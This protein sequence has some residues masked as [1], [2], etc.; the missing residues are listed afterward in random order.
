MSQLIRDF[1]VGDFGDGK[2]GDL[3]VSSNSNVPTVPNVG[4]PTTSS[5]NTV[6][7][8]NF[9]SFSIGDLVFIWQY[10]GP[11]NIVDQWE[12]N[13]IVA[14]NGTTNMTLLKG[15]SN[16]YTNSGNSRAIV[17]RIKRFNNLTVN[18]GVTWTSNNYLYMI[19]VYGTCTIT[20]TISTYQQ[21][22]SIKS[23]NGHWS[24]STGPQG[25]GESGVA[26][27][28]STTQNGTGG[29]GGGGG[30]GNNAAGGGGGG[31]RVV[32][33]NGQNSPQ[34]TGGTGGDNS[35]SSVDLSKINA[36]GSGG[37][38]GSGNDNATNDSG[39]GAGSL[40]IFAN[41][42]IVT[43]G[44]N[45]KGEKGNDAGTNGPGGGGSGAG[46]CLLVKCMTAQLGSGLIDASGG[47]R[48]ASAYYGGYGGA[49]SDGIIAISYGAS[50]IGDSTPA[51]TKTQVP[52]VASQQGGSIIPLL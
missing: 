18:S 5:G 35:Q 1:L 38:G 30:S 21:G 40:V 19:A 13:Y 28:Q 25:S 29:G 11:T 15:L 24:V 2:D 27:I 4:F 3:T 16:S 36:G 6:I 12:L 9:S 48:T 34:F 20:G 50:V 44:V 23:G 46:G 26:S 37:I 8:G 31:M 22:Y 45:L 14:I 52:L 51:A 17:Q 10:N 41:R 42:F 49:G 43:G 7:N 39:N 32:G 33:E 47:P